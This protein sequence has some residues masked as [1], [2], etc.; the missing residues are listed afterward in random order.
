VQGSEAAGEGDQSDCRWLIVS[1]IRW[2][3]ITDLVADGLDSDRPAHCLFPAFLIEVA[4]LVRPVGLGTDSKLSPVAVVIIGRIRGTLQGRSLRI[5]LYPH[6]PDTFRKIIQAEQTVIERSHRLVAGGNRVPH[7]EGDISRGL[8][9][10]VAGDLK[11]RSAHGS[12]LPLV[13]SRD[14]PRPRLPTG[15]GLG[16]GS[17]GSGV[18]WRAWAGSVSLGGRIGN[19]ARSAAALR[20][21]RSLQFASPSLECRHPFKCGDRCSDVWC[22]WRANAQGSDSRRTAPTFSLPNT[23][24]T[25]IIV[26]GIRRSTNSQIFVAAVPPP[27][28]DQLE[29]RTPEASSVGLWHLD[30]LAFRWAWT[31]TL[32]D[33]ERYRAR[34]AGRRWQRRRPLRSRLKT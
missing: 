20:P 17:R 2:R 5:V 22:E 30:Q 29:S 26:A 32:V 28:Q 33:D 10:I 1:H 31:R 34:T 7:L 14:A 9:I 24:N 18:G 19:L 15:S 3:N 27:S 13:G 23:E 11:R 6:Q 8:P 16:R 21:F 4:G 12:G 25:A